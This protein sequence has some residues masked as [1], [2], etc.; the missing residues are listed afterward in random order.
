MS[1]PE[2]RAKHRI[3]PSSL[4]ANV[5]DHFVVPVSQV[6]IVVLPLVLVST[7]LLCWGSLVPKALI[8]L[9][10]RVVLSAGQSMSGAEHVGNWTVTTNFAGAP[11]LPLQPQYT[12]QYNI[13][14][15]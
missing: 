9:L 5:I 8:D 12:R 7:S 13:S 14:L 2:L 11:G 3:D 4:A 6:R 15:Q 10:C 1:L